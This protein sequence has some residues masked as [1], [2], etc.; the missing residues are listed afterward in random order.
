MK[1]IVKIQPSCQECAE[2]A[3]LET[4]I[5]R[6]DFKQTKLNWAEYIGGEGIM[7]FLAAEKYVHFV[8]I[9]RK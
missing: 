2:R 9:S 3:A 7:R 1:N 8:C 4:D 5:D 6:S